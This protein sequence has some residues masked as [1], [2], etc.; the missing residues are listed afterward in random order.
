M[1]IEGLD[2]ASIKDLER[3][4]TYHEKGIEYISNEL[5]F[6]SHNLSTGLEKILSHEKEILAIIEEKLHKKHITKW[7]PYDHALRAGFNDDQDS[8]D[9]LWNDCDTDPA[10][11]S[12]LSSHI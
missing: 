8:I 11:G 1:K 10:G 5:E 4:V 2:K 7:L 6:N 3:L 9:D 12:G